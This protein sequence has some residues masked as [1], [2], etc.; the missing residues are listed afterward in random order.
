MTHIHIA[1]P[2]GAERLR[3][4][5]ADA[6]R[7]ALDCEAAGF[8]RYSD[9]LCLLQITVGEQTYVVDPLAFD[10]TE[11]LRAP[12]ENP[13]V[14]VIMHGADFDLRLLKRD[15]GLRLRGLV[16]TQ[17]SASLLGEESLGLQSLLE[18]RLGIRLSK[19]YQRA[20]WADRPLSEAMLEYA[21]DDTRYLHE[22]SDRLEAELREAGRLGWAEEEWRAL[23]GV[24]DDVSEDE[25]A[26]DPVVRVKGA[27]KLP[28]RTVAAIREALLWRDEIARARDRAPFRIV[29]DPPLVEAVMAGARR[30]EDLT[31]I[32]GFPAGLARDS[33]KDLLRRLR[34]IDQRP[35]TELEGYPRSERRGTG[36][37]P[38]ELEELITRLKSVRNRKAAE[39]GLPRGTVLPNAVI[40]SIA[41]EAPSDLDQLGGIDGMRRWKVDLVGADLLDALG[42]RAG[43]G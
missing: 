18:S 15:L 36:R 28:T 23:E 33:G 38:P 42:A 5:L 41:R 8:H 11:L 40:E 43:R 26:E 37:P 12:L 2:S 25:A 3:S 22:L 9:R 35:E 17:I 14:A 4:E 21:A 1:S 6:T 31:R 10:P 34:D 27:R 16:D 30:V 29:G 39:V 24:V 20:D 32:K 19:K 7:F 13:E